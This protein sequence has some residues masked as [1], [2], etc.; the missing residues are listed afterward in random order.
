MLE[1]LSSAAAGMAAQEE[2]MAAT[3]N[4]LANASTTGYKSVRVGFRDLMYQ[5]GGRPAADGDVARVGTGSAT[6][7]IGRSSVQGALQSTGGKLDVAVQGEGYLRVRLPDGRQGLTR[8][9][10]LQ[11][12][13]NGRLMTANGGLLQPAVTVP[14]GVS[15]DDIS[16]EPDGRIT[17]KG[18]ALGRLD[19]VTVPAR[20]ALE[21]VGD[22]AFVATAASGAVT[23]APASS[24]LA[25]GTLEA[26]SVDMSDAMVDMI[27]A[28]RSYQLA[29]KAIQTA[30]QMMEIANGIRR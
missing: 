20:E 27:D 2:R 29:S 30:D 3:A 1:A 24:T 18:R 4:D 13:G 28:Q 5:Q 9:G 26:S 23:R 21:P 10:S 12:D 22:N 14:K 16:I 15:K 8:D 7:W 11:V 6:S 19:L 25:A 17:A